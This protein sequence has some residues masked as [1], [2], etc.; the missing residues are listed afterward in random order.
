MSDEEM[1][2]DGDTTG[3][4]AQA[5]GA[6]VED[7]GLLI[8]PGGA[9]SEDGGSVAEPADRPA[10]AADVDTA[11][12]SPEPQFTLDELVAEM[13]GVSAVIPGASSSGVPAPVVPERID[14]LDAV[15]SDTFAEAPSVESELWTRAPFWVGMAAWLVFVGT[16]TYLLWPN[17]SQGL[18]A[19]P[20]YG[21]LVY[22]GSGLVL[23]GIIT[24]W[25]VWKRAR[26]RAAIVE[27]A[28][29]GRA[30]LLRALGWTAGGVA[31]WVV[32]MVVLSLHSLDVIP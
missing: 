23:L 6:P 7:A 16:L 11:E 24:G 13:A 17:A 9:E 4:V 15:M 5:D 27:R 19:A 32:A 14:A 28:V 22:G 30:V 26:A 29:V 21:V 10:P 31:I 1:P 3:Q 8:I 25:V 20:L 12:D 2:V 18:Q